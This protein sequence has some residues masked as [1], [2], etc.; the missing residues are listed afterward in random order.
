MNKGTSDNGP[1][2][3]KRSA[4]AGRT[5]ELSESLAQLTRQMGTAPP[6]TLGH[7]FSRWA[8]TVGETVAS[9]V[10][11]DR[12]DGDALVV[13]VDSPAW[14]SYLRTHAPELLAKLSGA[15]GLGAPTSLV[16]RVARAPGRPVAGA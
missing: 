2:R 11:P 6:A 1:R 7:I 12:I 9:H 16:I 3:P 10:R 13:T 5:L 15:A 14:A 4:R 8:E